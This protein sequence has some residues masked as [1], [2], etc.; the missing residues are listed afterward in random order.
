MKEQW[1]RKEKGE[2]RRGDVCTISTYYTCKF[3]V[4]LLLISCT[5]ST[6]VVERKR[7]RERGVY[8]RRE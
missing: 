8:R 7:E 3:T 2:E 5:I 4:V 6:T 1:T